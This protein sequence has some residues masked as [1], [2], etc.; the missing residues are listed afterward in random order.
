MEE[1]EPSTP[2]PYQQPIGD[3][4]PPADGNTRKANGRKPVR[5]RSH[6]LDKELPLNP[7]ERAGLQA[8]KRQYT[9]ELQARKPPEID[10]NHA[11]PD[12]AHSKTLILCEYSSLLLFPSRS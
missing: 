5:Q 3:L 8:Q 12:F 6:L 4:S 7:D 9:K 2:L 10:P 1:E 11:Y